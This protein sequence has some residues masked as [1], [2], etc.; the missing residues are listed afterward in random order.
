MLTS[1]PKGGFERTPA[2]YAPGH[3]IDT[4]DHLPIKQPAWTLPFV[5]R[6]HPSKMIDDLLNRG[7]IKPSSKSI[8]LSTKE[9]WYSLRL[10]IDYRKSNSVT[11]KDVYPLPIIDDILD[12]LGTSQ[13]FS[14]LDLCAGYWQIELQ[15]VTTYTSL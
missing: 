10:C 4:R 12:I 5:Y 14:C 6:E 9:R 13:H 1:L 11:R 15:P 2:V 3:G 7:I 8:G